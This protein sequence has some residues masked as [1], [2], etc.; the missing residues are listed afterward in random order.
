LIQWRPLSV[1]RPVP[2]GEEYL[3]AAAQTDLNSAYRALLTP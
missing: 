2:S 3:D 1:L